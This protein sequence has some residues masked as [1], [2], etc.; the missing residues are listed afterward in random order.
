MTELEKMQRAKNYIDQL[1][2]GIDPITSAE[3]SN[4]SVLNNVRLA[5]CFFYVS[6]ILSTVIAN[7]GEVQNMR[8]KNK[9]H[10][11][12]SELQLVQLSAT[13]IPVSEICNLISQAIADKNCAKLPATKITNWLVYKG[14][15][16]IISTSGK[17][18]KY[19]T[20]MGTQ[21]GISTEHRSGHRGDYD[22]NLYNQQAQQFLLDNLMAIL[23]EEITV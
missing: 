21:I 7:G 22:V 17:N 9:F 19:P 16:H 18:H 5:R 6:N 15:L 4:D 1:A 8:K 12:D 11:T 14:F 20:D 2:N 3:I 13:P 23:H 10:I